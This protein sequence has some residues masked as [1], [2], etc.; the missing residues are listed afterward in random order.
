MGTHAQKHHEVRRWPPGCGAWLRNNGER[1]A[2]L[3]GYIA[4]MLAVKD[5]AWMEAVVK[6]IHTGTLLRRPPRSITSPICPL[7]ASAIC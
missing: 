1:Q 4:G 3:P 2:T 5:M 7:W 6:P